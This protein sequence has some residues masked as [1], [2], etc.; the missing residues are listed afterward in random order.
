MESYDK[1]GLVVGLALGGAALAVVMMVAILAGWGG[2]LLAVLVVVG[3]GS[4]VAWGTQLP[5]V[6]GGPRRGDG[7]GSAG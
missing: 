7:R 2:L 1:A 5:A 3:M 4:A 6:D